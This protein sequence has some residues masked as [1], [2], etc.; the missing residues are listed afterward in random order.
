[1]S[2]LP[3]KPRRTTQQSQS[4][5]RTTSTQRVTPE[6]QSGQRQATQPAANQRT[7]PR[8]TDTTVQRRPVAGQRVS[9]NSRYRQPPPRDPFPIVIGAIVFAGLVSVVLIVLLLGNNNNSNPAT[10]PVGV[11]ATSTLPNS[12]GGVMTQ[13][14]SSGAT[15]TTNL[16][17]DLP[18]TPIPSGGNKHVAASEPITYQNYPPSS[19]THY[20]A[21]A[22]YGF[23]AVE[24]PEGQIVHSMEHGSVVL[25]YKPDVAQSVKDDLKKAYDQLPAGKYGKVK[26]V[27]APYANM[28][29]PLALAAW[30]RL[31][32]MTE[33]NY[34]TV[35]TFYKALVDKGPEDVP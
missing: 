1:M 31:L 14:T 32:P 5:Q 13:P 24:L 18:G 15:A 29:T 34:Q 30:T 11:V 3:P 21:T 20:D 8:R 7:A 22:P 33:Y 17:A 27:I 10:V 35:F 9:Q 6:R 16:S 4:S 25:Y 2:E 12:G 26:M 19:G 28:K 23:S